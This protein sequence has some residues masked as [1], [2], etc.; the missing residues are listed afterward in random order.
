MTLYSY[1]QFSIVYD[2]GRAE[3]SPD[4]YVTMADAAQIGVLLGAG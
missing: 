4:R 3:V 2:V 1:A